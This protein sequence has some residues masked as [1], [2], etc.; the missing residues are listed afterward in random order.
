MDYDLLAKLW[1]E[2]GKT[3]NE[4]A[5]I[6]GMKH[7][8]V[9]Y[10]LKKYGL[11]KSAYQHGKVCRETLSRMASDK[12]QRD[13]I[14]AHFGVCR[15]TVD[16]CA[17]KW[18][19]ELPKWDEWKGYPDSLTQEQ[20]DFLVG[21]ILGDG[22]IQTPQ[23]ERSAQYYAHHG[24]KQR[25]YLDW[26]RRLMIE[27][28]SPAYQDSVSPDSTGYHFCTGCHPL[29]LG[30]R[31]D[32][33]VARTKVFRESH[34]RRLTP[35]GLAVWYMD[36][37]HFDKSGGVS[38]GTQ[39]P[40]ESAQKF[41]S[42][43]YERFGFLFYP[44]AVHGDEKGRYY[45]R[46]R[47][48]SRPRFFEVIETHIHPTLRYKIGEDRVEQPHSQE[49]VSSKRDYLLETPKAPDTKTE[50]VKVDGTVGEGRGC[51]NGKSAGKA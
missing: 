9:N 29:F 7:G 13:V 19:I 15:Q 27:F 8:A 40:K 1:N 43:L 36:D 12:V 39:M 44:K 51:D 31:D 4:I 2:E 42:V 50:P 18:G 11:R 14:A 20:E 23:G 34:A 38:I 32:F 25:E 26:K 16:N 24:P 10:W 45:I 28:M 3:I 21:T 46:L 48:A 41:V 5:S 22:H 35:L 6:V 37:G 17:K 47:A 49:T 33:Y 30:W